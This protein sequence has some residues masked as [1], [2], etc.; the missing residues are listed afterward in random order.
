M[1]FFRYVIIRAFRNMKGSLFSNLTTVGIIG[2][3]MLIFSAFSLI[4]FNL[5]AFLKVLEEQ[6]AVI[7]YLK[8]GTPLN[9]VGNLLKNAR[10]IGGVETVKYLSPF[11][12]M[13]FMETKLGEQK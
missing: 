1:I 7:A 11:D 10:Q 8:K 12:A 4:A 6:I 9:D 3:S 13:A 2:F 5:T